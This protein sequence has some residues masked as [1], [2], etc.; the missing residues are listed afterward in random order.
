MRKNKRSTVHWLKRGKSVMPLFLASTIS[1]PMLTGCASRP[2]PTAVD[3]PKPPTIPA[4]LAKSSLPDAQACSNE[5]RKW[6]A[7]VETWLNGLQ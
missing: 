5:V 4:S 2:T 6:L 7:D 1:L 3:C